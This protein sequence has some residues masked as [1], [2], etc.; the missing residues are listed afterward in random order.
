MKGKEKMNRK[1]FTLIELLVVIAIIGI[2]AA[3]LLPALSRAREAARR[4]SCQNNLKQIGLMMKMFANESKGERWI[5]RPVRYDNSHT[6]AAGLAGVRLWHGFNATEIYPEYMTDMNIIFCPSDVDKGPGEVSDVM[7]SRNDG[8]IL[9]HI[10]TGWNLPYASPNP[11]SSKIPNGGD[12][13]MPSGN[14]ACTD[15]PG[16]CYIQGNDWSYMYWAVVINPL[17]CTTTADT[18]ELFDYLHDNGHTP[19]VAG[20]P[21]TGMGRYDMLYADGG[22]IL[23]DF[24]EVELLHVR[25][26][27]ERFMITDINNPAGASKAQSEIITFYDNIRTS[28]PGGAIAEGGKDFSHL[29][30]GA[31]VL[32]MDGHV[33][34]AKYPQP[35]GSKMWLVTEVILSDGYQ[36]SP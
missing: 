14:Y 36:Y 29:P 21:T 25:E 12:P 16:N 4:S 18:A 27:V 33:E 26:G 24:G 8:G 23:P 32:F 22:T 34:F 7:V 19:A 1:G 5:G 13:L 9:R 35:T 20:G 15:D 17:W 31:N 30:G 10:G 28:G 2:L 6:D 3:I 11:V